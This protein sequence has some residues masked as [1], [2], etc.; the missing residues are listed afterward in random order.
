MSYLCTSIE[1]SIRVSQPWHWWDNPLWWEIVLGIVACLAV[2]LV[3]TRQMPVPTPL[4]PVPPAV[5]TKDI[6]SYC[7][8]SPGG[9]VTP[10]GLDNQTG[11]NLG[12]SQGEPGD[13][14]MALVSLGDMLRTM[15]LPLMSTS[16][17]DFSGWALGTV[18]LPDWRAE[19]TTTRRGRTV[20]KQDNSQNSGETSPMFGSDPFLA[21][22]LWISSL[23]LHLLSELN[24]ITDLT[25]TALL[26]A[27]L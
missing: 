15:A 16:A 26:S 27:W 19:G 7:Q 22:Y 14:L 3:S 25:F 9:R 4:L 13:I 10:A 6:F 21:F 20:S 11:L 12:L 24:S 2:S 8:M 5:T 18:W 23:R 17:T 1:I